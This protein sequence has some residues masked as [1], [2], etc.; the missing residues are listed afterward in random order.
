M[1]PDVSRDWESF[2]RK[3]VASRREDRFQ[4]AAEA[5][6]ALHRVGARHTVRW[7]AAAVI[8]IAAVAGGLFFR[9][10]GILGRRKP[11]LSSAAAPSVPATMDNRRAQTLHFPELPAEV[12][13]DESVPLGAVS[14]SGLPVDYQVLGGPAVVEGG[15]LRLTGP[16]IVTVRASQGGDRDF[17]PA[18]LVERATMVKERPLVP[19]VQAIDFPP[20]PDRTTRDGPVTLEAQASSG[21]P[22][23]FAVISGPAGLEGNRLSMT[24]PGRVVVR[25]MQPGSYAYA[26]AEP[27]EQSF[28]VTAY[29][30]PEVV[31]GLPDGGEMVFKLVPP[32]EVRLGPAPGEAGSSPRDSRS[33]TF[34]LTAPFYL[35]ATEVTQKQYVA[36][37]GRD[38][39]SANRFDRADKSR[40]PIREHHPVEQIVYADLV[41]RDGLLERFNKLLQAQG[42]SR[43][44]A[45]LPDEA[46]WEYACRAGSTA[47]FAGTGNLA[48]MGW[49]AQN[50]GRETHAV[51]QRQPNAW[52]MFDMHGNVAEWTEGGHLRGGSFKDSAAACRAAARMPNQAA[53]T[54]DTTGS[55]GIR[56]ILRI[57]EG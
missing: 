30:D 44:R 42:V 32:G 51:A 48:D 53:R 27:V 12:M 11:S 40:R 6:K 20:L 17:L 1:R 25:A 13:V 31:I 2:Y 56:I 41:G 29:F 52:G 3:C 21:L 49:Y 8:A 28:V 45:A 19:Q 33:E 38:N 18:P 15:N 39:P 24:G 57:V 4:S 9:E 16:G 34:R 37:T 14:S 43:Y 10:T 36:I 55:C 26:A 5:R 54:R 50:S 7:L 47:P 46:E 23:F 35:A 22:V